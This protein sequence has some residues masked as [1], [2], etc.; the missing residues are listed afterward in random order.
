MT[1]FLARI[2][3]GQPAKSRESGGR[4]R[5]VRLAFVF[6]AFLVS[7]M[8]R[9]NTISFPTGVDF[10][11]HT[12]GA[13]GATELQWFLAS[14]PDPNAPQG[15]GGPSHCVVRPPATGW[16][17]SST[18]KW[19]GPP[20]NIPN[21]PSGTGSYVFQT[22]ITLP[23]DVDVSSVV[24][25]CRVACSGN[26]TVLKLNGKTVNTSSISA[27]AF[28]QVNVQG[29]ATSFA[30]GDNLISFTTSNPVASAL[31]LLVDQASITY[32]PL[33]EPLFTDTYPVARLGQNYS[34]AYS[35]GNGGIAVKIDGLPP[36][37]FLNAQTG[38]VSG[39]PTVT[40]IYPL[41]ITAFNSVRNLASKGTA[42]L[43]VTEWKTI[44]IPDDL[45]GVAFGNG[46]FVAVA[47][48]NSFTSANATDWTSH[49]IDAARTANLNCVTFGNG[50][51]VAGGDGIYSSPDGVTW[52]YRALAPGLV[53]ITYGNNLFVATS[54]SGD[55]R[56]SVDGVTWTSSQIDSSAQIF[57]QGL[58]SGLGRFVAIGTRIYT[59]TDGISWTS[60][61]PDIGLGTRVAFGNGRFV[62]LTGI[63][64]LVSLD[65]VSWPLQPETFDEVDLTSGGLGFGNGYFVIVFPD[66]T[67]FYSLDGGTWVPTAVGWRISSKTIAFGNNTFVAAGLDQ[68]ISHA[69]TF[70]GLATFAFS[71][72]NYQANENDQVAAVEINR[73]DDLTQAAAVLCK[74][75]LV[76]PFSY[77]EQVA[78]GHTVITHDPKFVSAYTDL[79]GSSY[80][81][82][83]QVVTF[84]PGE[85]TKTVSIPLLDNSSSADGRRE[86]DVSLNR[87][88]DG[89]SISDG[90]AIVSI[91]DDEKPT[92]VTG[93]ANLTKTLNGDLT[94]TFSADVTVEN[95]AAG[96]TGAIRLRLFAFPGFNNFSFD[97]APSLPAPVEIG[98]FDVAPSIPGH[99]TQTV[100]VSGV[101]PAPAGMGDGYNLWWWVFA[102]VEQRVVNS[103]LPTPGSWL[104]VDGARL[105]GPNDAIGSCG[106]I[107]NVGVSG[108]VI[109]PIGGLPPG[110]LPGRLLNIST[111]MLVDSGQNVLI[112]GVIVTGTGEKKIILRGI[113]PSL[114][115]AGIAN[116]L[117]DPQLELRDSQGTLLGSNDDWR[118][119]QEA[120]IIAT[121][122][123]P[124]DDREAALLTSIKPGNYTA[125]VRGSGSPGIGL[126]EIYDLDGAATT[127]RLANISTRGAVHTGDQVMIAGFIVSPDSIFGNN[128]LFRG[129]GPSL[130]AAGIANVLTDP[131]LQL[132]D[133]SGALLAS[134]N[135]W[136]VTIPGGIITSDQRSLIT[137]TT[138]PPSDARESAVTGTL[139]SGNYTVILDGD[140]GGQGI[141]LVEVYDLR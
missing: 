79:A 61:G 98:L 55:V 83:Y 23:D 5:A 125:I 52:T 113:G 16:T 135:D 100:G 68:I 87:L 128:L 32:N 10:K 1:P 122:I 104:L 26:G 82:V 73:S 58:T 108:G 134:N 136:Q 106:P 101:I 56:R 7:A 84:L 54:A 126:V 36:G 91:L 88:S 42:N 57:I 67:G 69:S 90:S 9:G 75:N 34:Y 60:V 96:A 133:S 62:A 120:A 85:T 74:T 112:G 107:P 25:A 130:T 111:R 66:G 63:G 22:H 44:P 131:Q 140:G 33:P 80:V 118:S 76:C 124:T 93:S 105:P 27:T 40:G 51:F 94:T 49:P 72:G 13:D 64:L 78:A 43:T 11:N 19:I 35:F 12:L 24:L 21:D 31:G 8:A 71:G 20:P 117:Q 86:I 18:A 77:T 41:Q 97:P 50:I 81:A 17:T 95:N 39:V 29:A 102:V 45:S 141:G 4:A 121:G 99:G 48:E 116:A 6:L 89:T 28:T 30:A 14:F 137:A 92:Q 3:T 127:S 70:P 65:G 138:I 132:R 2:T 59:S 114:V 123:P 46:T 119:N 110:P 37:L 109:N 53:A 115:K 15:Q 103:W 139:P 47:K 38:V 129:I